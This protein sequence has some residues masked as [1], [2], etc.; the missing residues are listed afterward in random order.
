M[1]KNW[2]GNICYDWSQ[3]YGAYVKIYHLKCQPQ[4]LFPTQTDA[5]ISPCMSTLVTFTLSPP[6]AL[7]IKLLTR[8]NSCHSK[9]K[10]RSVL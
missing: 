6:G 3:A 9:V 7:H 1:G 8:V 10:L 4:L 5:E 2:H